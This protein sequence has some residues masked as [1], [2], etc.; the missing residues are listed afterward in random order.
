M[1]EYPTDLVGAAQLNIV[2]I[3]ESVLAVPGSR[4]LPLRLHE[5]GQD[6]DAPVRQQHCHPMIDL[7]QQDVHILATQVRATLQQHRSL[8]FACRTHCLVFHLSRVRVSPL[9]RQ[10]VREQS[11]H[12]LLLPTTWHLTP[13]HGSIPMGQR[14]LLQDYPSALFAT[15][16]QFHHPPSPWCTQRDS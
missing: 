11:V 4:R 2:P 5:R 9:Q 1:R 14:M 6:E 10:H 8:P 16:R 12:V 13:T 7:Q 3:V 15:S